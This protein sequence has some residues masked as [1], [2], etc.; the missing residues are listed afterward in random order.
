[1]FSLIISDMQLA[2]LFVK[3][4]LYPVLDWPHPV[5][6]KKM[7]VFESKDQKMQSRCTPVIP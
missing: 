3:L 7:C 6:D 2:T 5:G 4:C 1:M